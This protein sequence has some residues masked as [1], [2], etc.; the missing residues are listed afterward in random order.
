MINLSKQTRINYNDEKVKRSIKK[1]KIPK[2][3]IDQ[4]IKQIYLISENNKK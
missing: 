2:S 3:F 4:I 1:M